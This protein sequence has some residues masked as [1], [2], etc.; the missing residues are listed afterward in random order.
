MLVWVA[1]DL[2]I[3]ALDFRIKTAFDDCVKIGVFPGNEFQSKI[4][5]S[6]E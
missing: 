3:Y 5:D 4:I 1:S 6:Y 2:F